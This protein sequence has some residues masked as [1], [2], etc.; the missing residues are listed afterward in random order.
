M[1]DINF[2]IEINNLKSSIVQKESKAINDPI[3]M[4][5]LVNNKYKKVILYKYTKDKKLLK[6]VED[7]LAYKK[8]ILSEDYDKGTKKFKEIYESIKEENKNNKSSIN[9]ILTDE[10]ISEYLNI[11]NTINNLSKG[12]NKDDL[13]NLLK[14]DLFDNI[15]EEINKTYIN[16]LLN[17]INEEI[18]SYDINNESIIKKYMENIISSQCLSN[19]RMDLDSFLEL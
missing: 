17:K 2:N 15:F 13:K 3:I 14:V 5:N 10:K 4:N 6:L 11:Y 18:S 8:M 9:K 12:E 19:Y 16:P 7:I 1:N